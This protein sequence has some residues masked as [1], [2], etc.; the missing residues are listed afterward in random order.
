MIEIFYD[1]FNTID[2]HDHLRQGSLAMEKSWHTK[3]WWH[4]VLCTVIAMCV[5]DAF[6]IYSYEHD[7]L[8]HT[9]TS[10]CLTFH[11]FSSKIAHRMIHFKGEEAIMTRSK[12]DTTAV[13]SNTVS[14][15]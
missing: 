2:V 6:R 1:A 12:T 15:M 10:E 9:N 7:N 4:R 13:A 8:Q 11:R 14:T 3:C 5:V